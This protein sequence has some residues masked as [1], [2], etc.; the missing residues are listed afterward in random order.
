M[1]KKGAQMRRKWPVLAA[2]IPLIIGWALVAAYPAA[3]SPAA[4][5]SGGWVPG[6]PVS[7]LGNP[8]M[9]ERHNRM[10]TVVT[11]SNWA[12]YADTGASNA[13]T[14]V[15]AAWV[16]PAATCASG[17]QYSAFWVGLDGYSS[18]TVEQTGS[19][20]DCVGRTAQYYA[21]WE[22]YPAAETEITGHT[23]KAGDH[24]TAS[25]TYQSPDDY[26]L[27]IADSTQSWSYTTTQALAGAKRSSA[28]V[29]AEAPCCT[30]RGG[31]LPLTNFG[32]VDFTSALVNGSALAT[33]TPVEIKMRDTTV[34]AIT[35]SPAENFGVTYSAVASPARFFGRGAF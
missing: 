33:L 19:A 24:F 15:S 25:V 30:N 28:E 17:D 20:A 8:S 7:H 13:F 5:G 11:S 27:V 34:T 18:S 26:V 35:G 3:A 31:I 4:F 6:G 22:I 16:Q 21:W 9:V 29:I 2:A 10:Q 23:V 32:T 14:S 12:G 1:G